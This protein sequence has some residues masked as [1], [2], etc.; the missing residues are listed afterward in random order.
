MF[1]CPPRW[2]HED[3]NPRQDDPFCG[4]YYSWKSESYVRDYEGCTHQGRDPGFTWEWNKAQR[5]DNSTRFGQQ[6]HSA[7]IQQKK[8]SW[9][10][11]P[12]IF[13]GLPLNEIHDCYP[14]KH[15]GQV[16]DSII[17]YLNIDKYEFLVQWVTTS[18]QTNDKA[19]KPLKS[20]SLKQKAEQV[21]EVSMK[22]IFPHCSCPPIVFL[23][24]GPKH[25]LTGDFGTQ[26]GTHTTRSSP[27]FFVWVMEVC[28][29]QSF[30]LAKK[31]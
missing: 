6:V 14:S 8:T 25:H 21:Q 16:T 10:F 19:W 28:R 7:Q 29:Q 24:Q 15:C 22:T 2:G 23:L 18:E 1:V 5:W 11:H 17:L 3:H 4:N 30:F 12:A 27:L 20:R 9:K 13:Q 31:K 26:H